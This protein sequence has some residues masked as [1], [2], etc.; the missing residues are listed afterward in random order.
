MQAGDI[1][2]I[3][4]FQSDGSYKL[5]PALLLKPM[6]RYNDFLVCGISTQLHQYQRNIGEILK[7]QNADFPGTGLR[8]TS[9]IRLLYLAVI[10]TEKISGS[11]GKIQ[12]L[13]YQELLQRLAKFI[14]S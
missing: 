13:L 8:K 1:I 3:D 7:E 6:P 10:P 9:V 14:V 4:M 11:I 2:L 5:R 12:S